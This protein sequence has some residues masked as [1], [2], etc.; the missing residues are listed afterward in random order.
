MLANAAKKAKTEITRTFR[1]TND[2][3]VIAAEMVVRRP[4]IQDEAVTAIQA[5]GIKL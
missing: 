5:R 2:E 4:L 3:I 1:Y